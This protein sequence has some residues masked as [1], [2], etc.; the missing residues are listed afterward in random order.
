[1]YQA[2]KR[3]GSRNAKQGWSTHGNSDFRC[4]PRLEPLEDRTLLSVLAVSK[5]PAYDIPA[6]GSSDSGSM[7]SDGRFVAFLSTA[8][9]LV[10][11]QNDSNGDY[12]VFLY[13]RVAGTRTLVSHS[14]SSLTTAGNGQ[15]SNARISVDGNFVAF[16]SFA[17]DLVPNQ[18]GS[19][20]IY[21]VF[22]YDRATGKN[23]LV[24][25]TS[26]SPSTSGNSSSSLGSISSDGRFA[27][28][29]SYATNLVNGQMDSN[30]TFDVFL[31][32][33]L[34]G[35]ITLVSHASGSTITT[36]NGDSTT[37]IISADGSFIAYTSSST[38]LVAG[39]NGLINSY[40]I[41]LYDRSTGATTLVSH[42]NGTINTTG[43]GVCIPEAIS[44]D[45]NI[46]AF[47]S[48]ATDLVPGFMDGN[49]ANSSDL[50]VFNRTSGTTTLVSHVPGFSSTSANFQSGP[51]C[52][53]SANGRFIAYDS[54]ATNLVAGQIDQNNNFDVF[55][56]DQ[57]TQINTMVSH[58]SGS[59]NTTAKGGSFVAAMSADGTFIAYESSATNLIP[60]QIDANGG[61]DFFLYNRTAGTN[62]L[63]SHSSSSITTT[64]SPGGNFSSG[65]SA[66][67]SFLAFLSLATNLVSGVQ[68]LG[69][70]F[71]VFLYS[72]A[73]D[74]NSLISLRDPSFRTPSASSEPS[75]S[76]DGR[77]IAFAS[78]GQ[79][80][81]GQV[82][83]RDRMTGITTL[84]SHS[85][86]GADFVGNADSDQP[87]MSADGRFVAFA[88]K[89]TDLVANQTDSNAATDIFVF[90][91]TTGTISPAGVAAAMPM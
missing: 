12:D 35:S 42:K 48:V 4:I 47:N 85:T 27:A 79:Q 74:T 58:V 54:K 61:D 51:D 57:T 90:D 87:A 78:T 45:G 75:V 88:S 38:N 34:S 32:D 76:A 6:S 29:L 31:F 39:Q 8:T 2:F 9:D 14:S 60:G 40:N 24:S 23:T 72:K 41:F 81:P 49:G 15:S 70:L 19:N 59:N 56:Y 20:S 36:G 83:L 55:F 50:F 46:I 18:T 25:H 65:I 37:P 64:G 26:A 5:V 28:F 53:M 7:S 91:R 86:L 17:T 77:Y 52:V 33:R 73:T 22:L 62:S 11:S 89:G 3:R 43:N 82:F 16:D 69:N 66:D 30:N 80:L 44:G 68:D 1:M 63:V 21:N 67:G 71:D 84:V 10:P 13:D